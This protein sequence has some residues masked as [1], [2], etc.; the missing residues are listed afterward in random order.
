MIFMLITVGELCE[1]EVV[2]T[3][4]G[5]SFGLADDILMDTE[6]RKAVAIIIKG[7]P[8]FFGFPKREEEISIPWDKI[9]TIG[10]DIVFVKTEQSGR[11]HNKK[12]NFIQKFFNFFFY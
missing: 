12:E 8:G 2:N 1:K 5:T 3:L 10:K 4:D 9:E 11:L 7:K 6:S